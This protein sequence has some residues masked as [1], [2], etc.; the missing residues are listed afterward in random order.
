MIRDPGYMG[1]CKRIIA[2]K[3][4]LRKAEIFANDSGAAPM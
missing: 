3:P 4:R 2:Q 1:G